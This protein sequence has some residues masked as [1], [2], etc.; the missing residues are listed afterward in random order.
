MLRLLVR[1]V[2]FVLIFALIVGGTGSVGFL[3]EKKDYWVAVRD[4]PVPANIEVKRPE[5]NPNKPTVAV[6]LSN[7]STEVFDFV[8]PYEMFAMT[9][10][11]NVFA[12]APD[13]QL[14]T[15]TGGLDLAPHYSFQEMDQ[16]L[17]KS[18][19]IIVIPY[20]P[21][22]GEEQYRP[23][24]EWIQ[25]HKET[26]ILTICG[27]AANLA[28]TGL[29]KGKT[30]T[31]HWQYIDLYA[32]QYPDTNWVRDQRY[33]IPDKNIVSSAG[34]TS[35]IDAVLYVIS[36]KL[37]EPMAEKIAK[38][39]NYPTYHF[40]HN[41]KVEPYR[42]DQTEAIYLANQ[43]FQWNET[44]IGVL[45]YNGMEDGALASIFDTYSA[46]GTTNVYT[47]SSSDQPIVTKHH[48]NLIA[49]YQQS[50][51]PA[52]D[53]LFVT[54]TDAKTL[55]AEE[56]KQWE[57]QGISVKPELIHGDSVDRF[58]FDAPLEDLAKQE[59]ILTAVYGAKRLEYRAKNLT[60]EGNPF[61]FES[62]GNLLLVILLA[63]GVA[64]YT[65]RRFIAKQKKK[66]PDTYQQAS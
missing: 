24:R 1:V 42:I 26:T 46:S 23:V 51:A 60:F 11:Y 47:I 56:I 33:V 34:L 63:V 66:T 41:P 28:D 31:L 58:I 25:K 52:L 21:I 27:G 39:M 38:E 44:A 36:Q 29:L 40:V 5:Y 57:K 64:F 18:P 35:G 6:M 20:M 19:D 12:V 55:A 45:L 54:G 32:K 37:G 61:S 13:N 3:L 17:G 62:F 15:I 43:A 2:V 8:V 50:N 59:D 10:A 14:K 22:V 4:Q 65:D 49:R 7:P 9:D 30:S 48:L 53:R 16:L